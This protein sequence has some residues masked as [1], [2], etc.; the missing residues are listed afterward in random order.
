MLPLG[1]LRV[2]HVLSPLGVER[3]DVEEV[4]FALRF[5]GAVAE[6][7]LAL[8]A[9]RAIGRNAAIIA[10]DAP[11]DVP[12]NPVHRRLRTRELARHG[13]VVVDDAAFEGRERWFAR[14]PGHLH[15]TKTMV[16]EAR[17][18]DLDAL[19]VKRINIR[20]LRAADVIKV[21]H[22]VPLEG[23][24]MAQC[25]F[26]A[27]RPADLQPAP[28]HHILAQVENEHARFGLRDGD[29]FEGAGHADGRHH[30]RRQDSSRRRDDVHGRP[31]GIVERGFRPARHL[32]TGVV[33]LA[34]VFVVGEDRDRRS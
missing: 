34:V 14:E 33:F 13:Q 19:A 18:M 23:L 16:S 15:V 5:L 31:A 9:L 4:G 21:K 3:P 6:P 32:F 30:P 20:H 10:A 25:H 17:L 8:V 29:G 7:A 1:L 24:G 27:C 26:G 28:T 2:G 12:V 11:D 22:A